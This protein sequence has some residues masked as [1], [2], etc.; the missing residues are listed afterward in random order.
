[1]GLPQHVG[2]VTLFRSPDLAEG[3]L[4][5]V[6]TPNVIQKSFTAEVLDDKGNCYLSLNGYQSV[7]LPDFA[8]AT[9]LRS[10]QAILSGEAV[11]A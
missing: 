1:M 9:R 6:V 4:Y 2:Q 3:R 11:A 10:L 7:A 5:A 8:D